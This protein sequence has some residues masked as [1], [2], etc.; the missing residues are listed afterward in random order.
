MKCEWCETEMDP[1]K[2][3]GL[4]YCSSDCYNHAIQYAAELADAMFENRDPPSKEAFM[5]RQQRGRKWTP[6]KMRE[7]IDELREVA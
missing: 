5:S 3:Y 7:R 2:G 4:R 1:F 6:D